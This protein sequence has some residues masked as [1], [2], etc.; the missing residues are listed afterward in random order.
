MQSSIT[1]I[2]DSTSAV[3]TVVDQLEKSNFGPNL[4]DC[5]R[6]DM[7]FS[8]K[9]L[10]MFPFLHCGPHTGYDQEQEIHPS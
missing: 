3:A 10:T 4:H 2:I 5:W 9:H 1:A 7:V 6:Q 8:E